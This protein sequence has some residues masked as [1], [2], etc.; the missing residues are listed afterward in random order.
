MAATGFGSGLFQATARGEIVRTVE[1]VFSTQAFAG[2]FL[3][4]SS[5]RINISTGPSGEVRVAARQIFPKAANDADA[6]AAAKNVDFEIAQTGNDVSARGIT[7]GRAAARV[8]FDVTVPP[9]CILDIRAGGRGEIVL[10]DVSGAIRIRA[11]GG[12]VR[13]GN[14]S[15]VVDVRTGGGGIKLISASR[16]AT[17]E[18]RSGDI[19][20]GPVGGNLELK[21]HSGHVRLS[22]IGGAVVAQSNHGDISAKISGVAQR[23]CLLSTT[24]GRVA[25]EA[26]AASAL[27]LDAYSN[28]GRV[29]AD[30]GSLRMDL[31]TGGFGKPRCAGRINAGVLASSGKP[32]GLVKLRTG[33]GDID[34]TA[35]P[36][37]L[38]A[39][40]VANQYAL[41]D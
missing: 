25:L 40:Y 41:A 16:L 12:A 11:A 35:G 21:T 39:A 32:A 28:A 29:Y 34:V 10:G 8:D 26:G 7:N 4:T 9:A 24:S 36:P 23:D 37:R 19:E 30:A 38:P 22:E 27:L 3:E 31:L 13:I 18:S 17:L 6:D 5:G 2:V 15:G 20:C 33:G 14:V 1:Q